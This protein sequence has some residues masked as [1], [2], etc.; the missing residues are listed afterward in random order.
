MP[1]KLKLRDPDHNPCL[2]ESDASMR[3]LESNGFQQNFCQSH[4][5]RYRNCRKFWLYVGCSR[6]GKPSNL[7]VL[8]PTRRDGSEENGRYNTRHADSRGESRHSS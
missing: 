3:C 2:T 5:I 7:Y 1:K 8:A 6:V 4:F